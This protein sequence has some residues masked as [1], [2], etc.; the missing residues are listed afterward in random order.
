MIAAGSH[1]TSQLERR[2]LESAL[3]CRTESRGTIYRHGRESDARTEPRSARVEERAHR[4]LA[5][6]QLALAR[7]EPALQRLERALLIGEL[8]L[9]GVESL[10]ELVEHKVKVSLQLR[11]QLLHDRA[12]LERG[13]STYW[14]PARIH[15]NAAVLR[16]GCSHHWRGAASRQRPAYSCGVA[17]GGVSRPL[18]KAALT[19]TFSSSSP[20]LPPVD[21]CAIQCGNR[22]W[23]RRHSHG[24]GCALGCRFRGGGVAFAPGA[25]DVV[26]RRIWFPIATAPR[27]GL[28]HRVWRTGGGGGRRNE[29]RQERPLSDCT[30][31]GGGCWRRWV[32]GNGG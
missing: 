4:R 32:C 11:T 7:V 21:E 24:V 12:C 16:D 3:R 14:R 17:L 19:P 1:H 15:R 10:I 25:V 29:P 5:P 23:R 2:L 27:L 20:R 6:P 13:G 28:R 18:S 30:E 8:R 9:F 22:R 26:D 31:V